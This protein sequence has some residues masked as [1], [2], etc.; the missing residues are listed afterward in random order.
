MVFLEI[1]VIA[2]FL[3]IIYLV[4]KNLQWKFKFEKR[5]EEF[6]E[7][8]E[9]KI[10]EDAIA[11]SARTLSGKTLEKLIPFLEKFK[12]NS[13]DVR[14]LGDPIDLVVFDGYSDGNPNKITFLEVKSG[15]SKLTSNQN[16]IRELVEKKKVDWEEFRI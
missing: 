13:H 6:L 11:R 5:V 4:F 7:K 1:T 16:K 15:D 10:R 12:H 3:V 2:L 9:R 14:W 8:E